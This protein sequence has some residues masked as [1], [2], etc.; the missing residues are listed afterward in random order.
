[1]SDETNKKNGTI[2]ENTVDSFDTNKI[3]ERV[4][5]ILLPVQKEENEIQE[6]E[7][8]EEKINCTQYGTICVRCKLMESDIDLMLPFK[9]RGI[10]GQTYKTNPYN[11]EKYIL[12]KT[13]ENAQGIFKKGNIDIVYY[14]KE[15]EVEKEVKLNKKDNENKTVIDEIIQSMNMKEPEIKTE[16]KKQ[17]KSQSLENQIIREEYEILIDRDDPNYFIYSKNK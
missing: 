15:K 14:Y 2:V 10:V 5:S 7:Y 16:E 1:M 3:D 4:I 9:K 6:Q 17:S 11:F 13:P 8:I 12:V